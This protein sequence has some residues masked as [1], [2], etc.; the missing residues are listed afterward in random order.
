MSIRQRL[1][2]P[3]SATPHR[4]RTLRA[5]KEPG[6]TTPP[7]LLVAGPYTVG[8]ADTS[9]TT[10]L[11][12]D[13]LVEKGWVGPKEEGGRHEE[14]GACVAV[15]AM[16]SYPI[17]VLVVNTKHHSLCCRQALIAAWKQK[18]TGC[19]RA[20]SQVVT[21]PLVLRT[22]QR[23]PLPRCSCRC[24]SCRPPP[25]PAPPAHRCGWGVSKRVWLWAVACNDPMKE[26]YKA[27]KGGDSGK[28]A[29][30]EEARP[31]DWQ[32]NSRVGANHPKTHSAPHWAAPS[33]SHPPVPLEEK[34]RHFVVLV[35][36]GAPGVAAH[37]GCNRGAGG[38]KV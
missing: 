22:T 6:P 14:S 17:I 16:G 8:P 13:S 18:K 10:K 32:P 31:D 23:M 34:V 28:S 7:C 12:D 38:S 36:R 21:P 20:P 30:R 19:P 1:L 5:G 26:F 11:R 15:Q 25:S 24:R 35:L 37:L 29:I 4:Q 33:P 3:C 27:A 2:A 9:I